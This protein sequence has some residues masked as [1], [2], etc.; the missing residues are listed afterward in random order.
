MRDPLLFDIANV[1]IL[2]GQSCNR[3]RINLRIRSGIA[4]HLLI[5]GA[6]A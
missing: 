4:R 6:R 3:V 1:R 5:F 2:D